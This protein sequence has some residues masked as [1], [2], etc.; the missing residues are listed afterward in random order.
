MLLSQ[1]INADGSIS[2]VAREGSEAAVVRGAV[3]HLCA[4]V[5][6]LGSRVAVWPK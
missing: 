3:Q 4:G 6:S 2:V 5:R 1:I